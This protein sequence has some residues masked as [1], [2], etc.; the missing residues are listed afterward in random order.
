VK[1]SSL[2]LA[3]AL[4]GVTGVN[5]VLWSA[6]VDS[7]GHASKLHGELERTRSQLHEAQLDVVRLWPAHPP[8]TLFEPKV[9]P[10][11]IK[12]PAE[13]PALTEVSGG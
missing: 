13:D 2:F 3:A 4:V 7:S 8:A 6:F 9:F 5:V 10:L 11:P 1:R 12:D